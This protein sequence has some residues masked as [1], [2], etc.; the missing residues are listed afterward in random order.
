M[1][2][3]LKIVALA[4]LAAIAYGIVH[5]LV[6]AHVCVEYFSLAHPNVIGRDAPPVAYAVVWGVIATWW[7]GLPLG[8]LLA[9]V[10]RIGRYNKLAPRHLLRPIGWLLGVQFGLSML[11]GVVGYRLCARDFFQLPGHLATLID[12]SRHERFAF[13]LFAHNAAYAVGVLGG[14]VLVALL[15][16]ARLDGRWLE[17]DVMGFVEGPGPTQASTTEP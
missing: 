1:L 16:K 7:V 5:D 9:W 4:V 13:D 14:L 15:H 2:A 3:F 17:L 10:S 8:V 12:R 11:A 6:T